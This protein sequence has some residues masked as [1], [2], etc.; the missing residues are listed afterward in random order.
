MVTDPAMYVEPF[1]KAGAN[2]LTFHIEVMEEHRVQP[3]IERIHD[4]GLTA[5]LAINPET[6]MER[7]LPHL[8]LP[9]LVLVMSVHPGFSGQSFI[10]A[11]LDKTRSL[12]GTMGDT[13]RLQMDGGIAPTNAAR[14]RAAGCDVLVAAS[15]IF[16]KPTALRG[17]IIAE[18]RDN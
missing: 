1:A 15:A 8:T 18:L 6:P 13:Q 5:G 11:S 9:N 10:G 3:M 16:G 17:A 14:V 12:R 7:L 4:C 2:H